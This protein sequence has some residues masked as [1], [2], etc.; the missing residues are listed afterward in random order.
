M[1]IDIALVKSTPRSV[2]GSTSDSSP[3][4]VPQD[5]NSDT[6][7]PPATKK[8]D[9]MFQRTQELCGLLVG[10]AF[11]LQCVTRSLGYPAT[12]EYELMKGTIYMEH[13]HYLNHPF[14]TSFH[15]LTSLLYAAPRRGSDSPNLMR[16]HLPPSP[17]RR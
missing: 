1:P 16:L 17:R 4:H 9:L 2:S 3:V 11:A 15:Q 13:V 5:L 6:E 8:E 10:Y 12:S 14:R 7:A